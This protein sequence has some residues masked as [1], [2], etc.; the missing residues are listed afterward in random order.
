MGLMKKMIVKSAKGFVLS[1]ATALAV[2][3]ISN[4]L[5]LSDSLVGKIL[6]AGIPMMT[7]L[8]ADDPKITDL[9]FKESK[10]KDR[11]KKKSRKEAEDDFFNIFG[12]KGHRMNKAITEE[13]GATEEE[14]NGVMGLFMPAFIDAIAEE[15]PEDS[16]ALGNLFR[17]DVDEVK[18]QGPS[19]LKMTK[20]IIF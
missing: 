3:S 19:L 9:L 17:E 11:K 16:K 20:K 8:A 12:D 7:F 1:S 10:K 6:F 14:V 13:T 18:K 15:E 5:G 2:K 4:A